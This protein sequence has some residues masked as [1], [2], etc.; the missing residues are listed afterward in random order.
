MKRLVCDICRKDID[1]RDNYDEN[2][3]SEFVTV[4]TLDSR[5]YGNEEYQIC[6]DCFKQLL[7]YA[8]DMKTGTAMK[9]AKEVS[10]AK[11]DQ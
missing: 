5:E 11:N 10:E 1:L 6:N 2:G 4:Q 9:F 3:Y 8:C 7:I